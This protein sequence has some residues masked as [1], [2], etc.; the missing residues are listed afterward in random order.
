MTVSIIIAVK[1]WQKNLEEC[2]AR[3]LELDYPDFEIIILPDAEIGTVPV[4]KGI[5][6]ISFIP[7]GPLKPSDKRDI[8]L[9]HAKGQILAF[10]DDDAYPVK[11]W[12]KAALANFSDPEVAAVGGPAVTPIDDSW[13]QKASGI[14]YESWLMSGQHR[15]RYISGRKT[16]V[17]D[18]PSCNLLVRKSV[19]DELGGFDTKFWPGEDT[20]LCL[21]ITHKL[22]KRIVYDPAVLVSHHRRKI[23]LAHLKQISSYGLHRG[24]FVK[25]YPETS[26]RLSYFLPSV[27][28]LGLVLGGVLSMLNPWLKT[29]YLSCLGLYLLLAFIS[30]LSKELQLI[31]PVF[32]AIIFSH[33][34]YGI[35]FLKGLLSGRL[36]EGK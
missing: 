3:C 10:I 13:R 24:Y 35:F 23:Y 25:K 26:L 17:D 7:T 1:T 11:G 22:K 27:F 8:A 33:I 15:Y 4:F 19:M 2:V 12:L 16:E 6:P 5:V 29:V 9:K 30:S 34:T 32:F 31:F 20:K 21:D 18:Y 14:V 28:V 36:S